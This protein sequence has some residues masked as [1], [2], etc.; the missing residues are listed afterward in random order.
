MDT[1]LRSELS[2]RDVFEVL[3]TNRVEVTSQ[4]LLE[5]SAIVTF[6][7][8]SITEQ[9][10]NLAKIKCRNDNVE[11]DKFVGSLSLTYARLLLLQV[12]DGM[13]FHFCSLQW[14]SDK[15][16]ITFDVDRTVHEEDE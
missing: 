4:S 16:V 15:V 6:L 13:F 1:Q 2:D 3:L 12:G 8:P 9:D 7:S 5:G 10:T 11:R 14:Q